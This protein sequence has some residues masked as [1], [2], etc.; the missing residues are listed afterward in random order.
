MLNLYVQGIY[1]RREMKGVVLSVKNF[2]GNFGG[3]HFE[4]IKHSGWE[5]GGRC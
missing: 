4:E 3:T 2:W 1:L 5:G